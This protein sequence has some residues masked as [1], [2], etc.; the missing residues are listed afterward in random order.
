M[1]VCAYKWLRYRRCRSDMRVINKRIGHKT[2]FK[3]IYVSKT[4]H[5]YVGSKS[6]ILGKPPLAFADYIFRLLAR[7]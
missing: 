3:H 1:C 7:Y 6:I 5:T 4:V 2:S